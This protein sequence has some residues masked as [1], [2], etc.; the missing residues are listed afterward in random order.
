VFCLGTRALVEFSGGLEL[1]GQEA[2]R[3]DRW[4]AELRRST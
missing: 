1:V 3:Q 2:Y 4:V